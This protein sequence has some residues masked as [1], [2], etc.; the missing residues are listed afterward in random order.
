ML[1]CLLAHQDLP[2]PC[3]AALPARALPP[4]MGFHATRRAGKGDEGPDVAPGLRAAQRLPLAALSVCGSGAG[5]SAPCGAV[6]GLKKPLGPDLRLG[7]ALPP[8][9]NHLSLNKRH[10]AVTAPREHETKSEKLQGSFQWLHAAPIVRSKLTATCNLPGTASRTVG[11]GPSPRK[12]IDLAGCLDWVTRPAC[13]GAALPASCVAAS[14]CESCGGAGEKL[15]APAPSHLQRPLL[16]G[17]ACNTRPPSCLS[18]VSQLSGEY[19]AQNR[20]GVTTSCGKLAIRRAPSLCCVTVSATGLRIARV[21][22]HSVIFLS[23]H[24]SQG[25]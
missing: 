25:K 21:A 11:S 16:P 3:A 9:R 22:K 6:C 4:A 13:A 7:V 8:A 10:I 23:G 2:E 1:A 18:G 15:A 14:S 20:V 12:P 17:R 5:E 19:R 24:F